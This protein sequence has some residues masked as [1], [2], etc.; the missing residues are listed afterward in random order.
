[1][2]VVCSLLRWNESSRHSASLG[3]TQ[4]IDFIEN[5]AGKKG[6]SHD[7]LFSLSVTNFSLAKMAC[8]SVPIRGRHGHDILLRLKLH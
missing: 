6:L 2:L 3:L 4:S 8:Q 5:C 7:S 1:M